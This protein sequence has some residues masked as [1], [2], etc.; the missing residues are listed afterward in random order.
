MN[1][2]TS[3]VHEIENALADYFRMSGNWQ[4]TTNEGEH[5]LE[6]LIYGLEGYGIDIRDVPTISLWSLARE[7]ERKLS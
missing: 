5:F 7:L 6:P 4:I 3:R 2:I 1:E